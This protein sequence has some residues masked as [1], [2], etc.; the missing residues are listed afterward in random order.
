MILSDTQIARSIANGRIQ[1]LPEVRENQFR[2]T[3]VRIHLAAEI[4]LPR[5][6]QIVDLEK[7]SDLDFDKIDLR[8]ERFVLHPGAYVLAATVERIKVSSSILPILEGRSTIARLGLT[9]HNTASVLDV[10]PN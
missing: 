6:G 5:S 10:R 2:P 8:G 1:F 4:L 7:P 3:G 9:I